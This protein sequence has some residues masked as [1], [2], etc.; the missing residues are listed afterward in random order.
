MKIYETAFKTFVEGLAL[1]ET[2]F[3]H[4][5]D[6]K[7]TFRLLEI[8]V[9]R[10]MKDFANKDIT[11]PTSCPIFFLQNW[12]PILTY[13]FFEKDHSKDQTLYDSFV[14]YNERFMEGVA[15]MVSAIPLKD[16]KEI[17]KLN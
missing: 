11:I 6:R 15:K 2:L 17:Y 9:D 4:H 8:L 12:V 14:E 5:D 10:Y 13:I 16:Q 3:F 1:P 7:F